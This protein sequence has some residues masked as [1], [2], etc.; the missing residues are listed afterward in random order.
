MSLVHNGLHEQQITI[1]LTKTGFF[2]KVKV[3]LSLCITKHHTMKT[4]W[5]EGIGP[6]IFDLN[7]RR[8][9]VAS[10]TPWPL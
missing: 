6:C 1:S 5:D 2:L 9:W 4:Y 8:R 3:K 10:F 7:T